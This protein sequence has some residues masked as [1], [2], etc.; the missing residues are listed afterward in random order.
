M[1]EFFELVT[2]ASV[3][4][5][6]LFGMMIGAFYG[7]TLSPSGRLIYPFSLW[8]V[9]LGFIVTLAIFTVSTQLAT[10]PGFSVGR[11]VL[12][13]VTCVSIPV[14]RW[15]RFRFEEWRTQR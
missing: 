6:V 15:L 14:G 10:S 4:S 11:A 3:A 2:V 7:Y 5:S 12:W 9:G 8:A 1:S 13:T